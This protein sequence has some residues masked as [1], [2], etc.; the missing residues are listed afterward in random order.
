MIEYPCPENIDLPKNI[1]LLGNV[2]LL[3]KYVILEKHDTSYG[4]SW[5]QEAASQETSFDRSVALL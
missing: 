1:L 3:M 5:V 4:I 2:N